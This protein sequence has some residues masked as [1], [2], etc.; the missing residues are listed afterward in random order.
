MYGFDRERLYRPQDKEM[1]QIASVG[2]LSQWRH[3]KRT[4]PPFIRAGKT[5]FYAGKD[6]IDWLNKNRVEAA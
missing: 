6:L 3:H 1:R 5:I 2:Q 4:G